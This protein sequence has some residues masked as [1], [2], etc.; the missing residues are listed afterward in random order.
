MIR[1]NLQF[2]GVLVAIALLVGASQLEA[3]TAPTAM[4]PSLNSAAPLHEGALDQGKTGG[5]GVRVLLVTDFISSLFEKTS[6]SATTSWR[7]VRNDG[8]ADHAQ[9]W[10]TTGGMSPVREVDGFAFRQSYSPAEGRFIFSSSQSVGSAGNPITWSDAIRVDGNGDVFIN[11]LDVANFNG[12]TSTNFAI[13]LGITRA[14]TNGSADIADQRCIDAGFTGV[15]A[16][17]DNN[18]A[19]NIICYTSA[20]VNTDALADG[21]TVV[22]YWKTGTCAGSA[23]PA[24]ACTAEATSGGVCSVPG[25]TCVTDQVTKTIWSLTYYSTRTCE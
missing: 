19:E 5:L 3:W 2:T 14:E 7:A 22:Y 10:N 16:T 1:H 24:D 13:S 25:K 4:P 11:K 6:T 18:G 23:C 12:A 20:D 15:W 21:P 17:M 8:V 9:Y